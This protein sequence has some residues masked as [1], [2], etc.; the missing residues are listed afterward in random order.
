M[1]SKNGKID[2]QI[3]GNGENGKVAENLTENREKYADFNLLAKKCS[4]F[5][6]MKTSIL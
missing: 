1:W 3:N 6:L 5:G 4:I 2:K